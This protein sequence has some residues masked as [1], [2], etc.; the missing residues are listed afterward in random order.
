MDVAERMAVLR[1]CLEGLDLTSADG[2]AGLRCALREVEALSRGTSTNDPAG[3]SRTTTFPSD[4]RDL[5]KGDKIDIRDI[6]DIC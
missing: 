3:P 6:S 2:R 4:I 5:T 1:Q